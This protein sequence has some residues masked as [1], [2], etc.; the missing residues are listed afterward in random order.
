MTVSQFYH[1]IV[2]G[3]SNTVLHNA[4]QCKHTLFFF[5]EC[6]V[7]EYYMWATHLQLLI[8]FND[9]SFSRPGRL[10]LRRAK[11]NVCDVHSTHYV[12]LQ[13]NVCCFVQSMF[14]QHEITMV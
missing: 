2:A 8:S 6:F 13:H 12:T 3:E 5:R 14:A 1:F 4:T 7:L 11:H 9:A 10:I